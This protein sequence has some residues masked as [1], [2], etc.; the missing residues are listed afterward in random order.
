[1]KIGP[2]P[3]RPRCPDLEVGVLAARCQF[4]GLM[5]AHVEVRHVGDRWSTVIPRLLS[6]AMIA[7]RR[8][9]SLA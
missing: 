7:N 1:M 5:N 4:I 6:R 3:G 9:I 2:S 8:P